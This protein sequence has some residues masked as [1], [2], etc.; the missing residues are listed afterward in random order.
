MWFT[1]ERRIERFSMRVTAGLLS[2]L[3]AV[4]AL[5]VP[6]VVA[7]AGTQPD[8]VISLHARPSVG[9]GL[10]MCRDWNPDLPCGDFT[11]T[12][13]VGVGTWVYMVVAKGDSSAGIS[14]LH[15]RISYRNPGNAQDGIGA[16]VFG[17]VSCADRDFPGSQYYL[18]DP[19][20][21]SDGVNTF[22]WDRST[23]CQRHVVPPY[24][25]QAVACA[26][27]I[28][29]YGPDVFR[30]MPEYNDHTV[31]L[32]VVDCVRPTIT[33]LDPAEAAGAIGFG[34]AGFNPCTERLSD[35]PRPTITVAS[36][37]AG[38]NEVAVD[39]SEQMA[40]SAG[41]ASRYSVYAS[42]EP[43]SPLTV[44]RATVDGMR[45]T[46]E[47]AAAL[48]PQTEYTVSVSSVDGWTGNVV[49]P[50]SSATFTTGPLDTTPPALVSA[51]GSSGSNSVL[52]EFSEEVGEGGSTASN[53]R[54]YPVADP[55]VPNPVVSAAAEG[56]RVTLSLSSN[57]AWG[58]AYEVS[59]SGVHDRAG[60]VIAANSAAGFTAGTGDT[61]PPVLVSVFGTASSNLLRLNFSETVAATAVPADFTVYPEAEPAAAIPV[62]GLSFSGSQV[63]LTLDMNLAGLTRYVVAVSNVED[64]F[65]NAILPN[66]MITFDTFA[67]DSTPLTVTQVSGLAGTKGISVIFSEALGAGGAVAGNYTV[68][69]AGNPAAPLDI[70]SAMIAPDLAGNRVILFL[71]R[72]LAYGLYTV[73]ISNVEDRDGNT[74]EPGTTVTFEAG[75]AHG[76]PGGQSQSVVTLHAQA[77]VAKGDICGHLSPTLS[78]NEFVH[79]W[80]VGQGADVY[81]VV[82]WA[83][84][85]LGISGLSCGIGYDPVPGQGCDVLGYSS[86]ADL[87]Y[88]NAGSN[89]EWPASHGGNR[90]IWLRDTN[91][92]RT[93]RP[94]CAVHAVAAG[95]YVY[96]YGPDKF[97]VIQNENLATGPEFAVTD[98]DGPVNSN[99]EF[100]SHAGRIGFGMA[101]YNPCTALDVP[102]VRTTWGRLKNQY[103]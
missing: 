55:S 37:S 28:Y 29:A 62:A 102:T 54:V 39:F 59:V 87:E 56:P 22:I 8:A 96:A 94:A 35:R 74:I 36:G 19:F 16:D 30:V 73:V 1:V 88:T 67:A 5:S 51:T 69:P 49:V 82:A 61:T 13:P 52:V 6:P 72:N 27:Y 77:H 83:R 84:A 50:N 63:T 48:E 93:E 80:P 14:G 23:N 44:S 81:L 85:D 89:G 40:H 33:N 3:L 60:N 32:L 18:E 53:F 68:Y 99:M 90:L 2:M 70:L 43:G 66:S 26:F 65:G 4:G 34:Q 78:C 45:V 17:Y 31:D 75:S 41:Y 71:A 46:L 91:C 92:Q 101:G 20:P 86:C 97:A 47:M 79:T 7:A 76:L 57:L 64:A 25:V 100:P 11:T 95:F 9:Q 103:H 12:W 10:N 98:C 21:A 38:D 42:A 58:T 15:C 24:G